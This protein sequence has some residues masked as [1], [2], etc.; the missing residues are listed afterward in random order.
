MNTLFFSLLARGS[1]IILAI[2]VLL[3]LGG[4]D[5]NQPDDTPATLSG[6]YTLE[7]ISSFANMAD[8]DLALPATIVTQLFGTLRV[9]S[10]SIT[11]GSGGT[12][13]IAFQGS[14]DNA[15]FTEEGEGTYERRGDALSFNYMEDPTVLAF[16]GTVD[17]DTI[18][19]VYRLAGLPYEM[20]MER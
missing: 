4:C 10:G 16:T 5:A 18:L 17:G 6:T 2:A 13:S 3:G 7:R 14:V 1:V 12:Y 20:Q 9:T 15:G 11:F 19:L 8:Q